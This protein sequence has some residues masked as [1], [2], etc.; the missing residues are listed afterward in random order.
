MAN[1]GNKIYSKLLK[2]TNDINQYP[3]D[4]NNELCS[5]S[6]LPQ[7]EKPNS[8]GDVNYIAP[9]EDLTNCQLP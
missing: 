1:T 3:L 4:V 7:D 6:G 8:I 2:V 5:V 9:S